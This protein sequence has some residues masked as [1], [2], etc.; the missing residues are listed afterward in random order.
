MTDTSKKPRE[1]WIYRD[2]KTGSCH[3]STTPIKDSNDYEFMNHLIEYSAYQDMEQQ[4]QEA[5]SGRDQCG[6]EF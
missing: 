2:L 6:K 5:V 4:M 3:F 1:F